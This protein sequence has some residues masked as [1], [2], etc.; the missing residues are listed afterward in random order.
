MDPITD[1]WVAI[2]VIP[3]P[4]VTSG[5][6]DIGNIAGGTVIS[7]FVAAGMARKGKKDSSL[8]GIRSG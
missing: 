8:C 2:G 5:K 3:L 4:Q 7:G 6:R 1:M